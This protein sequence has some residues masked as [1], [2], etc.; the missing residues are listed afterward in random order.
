MKKAASIL[1]A[2]AILVSGGAVVTASESLV[3]KSY[4]DGT[5][6]TQALE[7]VSK[8]AEEEKIPVYRDVHRYIEARNQACAF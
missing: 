7:Q 5:F 6:T 8:R 4:V 2:G 3:S 1:L